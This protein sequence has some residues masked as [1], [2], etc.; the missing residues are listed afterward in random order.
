[1]LEIASVAGHGGSRA[2]AST[3]EKEEDWEFKDGLGYKLKQCSKN[4]Q[5]GRHTHWGFLLS[6]IPTVLGLYQST[7]RP[8]PDVASWPWTRAIESSFTSSTRLHSVRINTC[9]KGFHKILTSTQPLNE[10]HSKG[11]VLKT[12]GEAARDKPSIC[13]RTNLSELYCTLACLYFQNLWGLSL[14]QKRISLGNLPKFCYCWGRGKN[15][16]KI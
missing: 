11:V 4:R 16:T 3:E 12:M 1:M 5:A 10:Q 13:K 2:L 9:S 8:S 14:V 7:R 15:R 6:F